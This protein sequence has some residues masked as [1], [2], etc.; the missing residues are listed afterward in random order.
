MAAE[1]GDI[2]HY[3]NGNEYV[4]TDGGPVV[5]SRCAACGTPA[6]TTFD[7]RASDVRCG[8]CLSEKYE[9]LTG[10]RIYELKKQYVKDHPLPRVRR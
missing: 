9:L 10:Q 5:M 2:C 4:I 8:R 1:V 3:A 7:Y 6:G